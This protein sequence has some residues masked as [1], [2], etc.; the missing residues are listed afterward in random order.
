[1][2]AQIF[3][4]KLAGWFRKSGRD[5]PWRRDRTPYATWISEMMLQQTQVKTML[6]YFDAWMKAFPSVEALDRAPLE[7]VLLKWQGLGYYAR[8]RNIKKCARVLVEKHGGTLPADYDGLQELPGIGPYS[9]GAIASIGFGLKAPIVDGNVLRVLAR[10]YAITDPIDTPSGRDRIFKLQSALVPDKD[11][12]LFNEGLMELGA[13]ICTPQNPSCL[14]CPVASECEALRTGKVDE[15]PRR[16]VEKKVS[17]VRAWAVVLRR[18]DR[19]FLHRRPEGK[20]MGGFWEFPEAKWPDGQKVSAPG[21]RRAIAAALGLPAGEV[22]RLFTLKRHYTRFAETLNVYSAEVDA[23][24]EDLHR[25]WETR[26]L[27]PRELDSLPLTSA[28]ARIRA[29]L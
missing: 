23:V 20:I 7:K 9:A 15:L 11:P 5:L 6:P 1:M 19:Y 18:K 10:V 22:I 16:A 29:R 2:D 21:E 17:K 27:R 8:A 12:G 13:L 4:Q 25:G 24:P 28:H 26:W 14:A 3:R